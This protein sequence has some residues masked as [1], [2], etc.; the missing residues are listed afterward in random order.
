MCGIGKKCNELLTDIFNQGKMNWI[1]PHFPSVTMTYI[2]ADKAD[3]V[4]LSNRKLTL[5]Y[6]YQWEKLLLNSS[7]LIQR[8]F[9]FFLHTKGKWFSRAKVKKKKIDPPV[10]ARAA[11]CLC[12]VEQ[13]SWC[14]VSMVATV[15]PKFMFQVDPAPETQSGTWDISGGGGSLQ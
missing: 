11:P 12:C 7:E 3:E 4:P 13:R 2:R 6:V 1:W 14:P 8:L 5:N 15:G 9:L 10:V